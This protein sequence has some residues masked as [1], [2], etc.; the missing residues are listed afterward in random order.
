MPHVILT[1]CLCFCPL[2]KDVGDLITEGAYPKVYRFRRKRP[3]QNPQAN[4]QK[5]QHKANEGQQGPPSKA[6]AKLKGKLVTKHGDGTF[7]VQVVDLQNLGLSILDDLSI[8]GV[9]PQSPF[10]R[11]VQVG[12]HLEAVDGVNVVNEQLADVVRRIKSATPPFMLKLRY[13]EER[14]FEDSSIPAQKSSKSTANDSEADDEDGPPTHLGAEGELVITSPPILAGAKYP[15]QFATFGEASTCEERNISM[16]VDAVNSG[17]L[18]MGCSRSGPAEPYSLANSV[19]FVLR[20]ECTFVTKARNINKAGG[21]GM[22]VVTRDFEPVTTMPAGAG[23]LRLG[24]VQGPAAMISWKDGDGLLGLLRKGLLRAKI[25]GPHCSDDDARPT[26]MTSEDNDGE[27]FA[28]EDLGEGRT[29]KRHK[30]T[31]GVELLLWDSVSGETYHEIGVLGQIG[32]FKYADYPTVSLAEPKVAA[33]A[34]GDGLGCEAFANAADFQGAIVAVYRGECSFGDKAVN[35]QKA[36]GIG[37]IVIN[38]DPGLNKLY[39]LMVPPDM[40]A[41]VKIPG[42]MISKEAGVRLRELLVP[43][44]GEANQV[45]QFGMPVKLAPPLIIAKF[46]RKSFYYCNRNKG[47]LCGTT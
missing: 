38:T 10:H 34:P 26:S 21:Q 40:E 28:I 24:P 35:I 33:F 36:G 31:D 8:S 46:F 32:G 27:E 45:D 20:G 2:L 23:E 29:R 6:S 13:D 12:D 22:I 25:R 19:V 11:I 9:K 15:I 41:A 14:D 3:D 43:E 7:S 39:P 30:M 42:I 47:I 1:S 4:S 44:G 17:R 5:T 37:M 18:G 16:H